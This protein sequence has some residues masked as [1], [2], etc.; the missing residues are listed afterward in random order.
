MQL[1]YYARSGVREGNVFSCVCMFV[2]LFARLT[3]MWTCSN[4]FNLSPPYPHSDRR[5][6]P[7][8]L[9]KLVHFRTPGPVQ[10]YSLCGP[11]IYWQVS[12]WPST[13]NPSCASPPQLWKPPHLQATSV[14]YLQ[15]D[16]P[17]TAENCLSQDNQIKFGVFSQKVKSML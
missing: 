16:F 2:Y 1:S 11:Y 13:I 4:L 17:T 15:I 14:S 8:N 10:T 9:F 3:P 6:H 7:L 12:S 5:S